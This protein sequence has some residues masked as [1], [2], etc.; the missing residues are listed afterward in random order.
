MILINESSY[1][2]VLLK[3]HS[4]IEEN[5]KIIS[6]KGFIYNYYI[7]NE[8]TIKEPINKELFN[9]LKNIKNEII[10]IGTDLD[11]AGDFIA[12][13]INDLI[14]EKNEIFRLTINF[15]KLLNYDLINEELLLKNSNKK[16]NFSNA[17][18]YWKNFLNKNEKL[19]YLNIIQNEMKNEIIE[20][21]E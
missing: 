3:K 16:I 6:S 14:K 17:L 11:S 12:I 18:R 8:K 2:S 9:Y 1:M 15:D 4:F 19:E 21:I 10:I 7:K 5:I 13:E 20:G